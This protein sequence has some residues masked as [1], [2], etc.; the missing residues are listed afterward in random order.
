MPTPANIVDGGGTK[1]AARVSKNGQLIVAVHAYDETESRELAVD[2]TAYNFYG[3]RVGFKFIITGMLAFADK[4][5]GVA[6]ATVVVY[7]ATS[8]TD[9]VVARVLLPLEIPSQSHVPVPP[10]NIAVN[11]GVYINAKTDDDDVHMTIMGYFIKI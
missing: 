6:N 2:D 4:Q 1:S 11:P 9:L 5:V 10:L 7:E 8:P 3:P